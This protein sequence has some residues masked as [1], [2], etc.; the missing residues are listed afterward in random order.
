MI[1]PEMMGD[2]CTPLH[3]KQFVQ[4]EIHVVCRTHR[5]RARRSVRTE[6]QRFFTP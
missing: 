4:S 6:R 5:R 2:V 3:C 1:E